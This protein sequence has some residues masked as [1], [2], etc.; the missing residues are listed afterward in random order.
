MKRR[1]LRNR[2]ASLVVF[3]LVGV[4][5]IAAAVTSLDGK[6]MSST[7]VSTNSA[8]HAGHY[9]SDIESKIDSSKLIDAPVIG[10]SEKIDLIVE[11]DENTLI[12]TYYADTKG[13]ASFA[14]YRES[15]EGRAAAEAL[16][17]KQNAVFN[18]I[19]R[20]A[21]VKL[22]YNYV[23][24]MNGFSMEITYGDREII[25][26][27][28]YK[29]NVT[30]TLISERYEAPETQDA[31]AAVKN[32]VSALETG[33]F[34]SSKSIDDG[35]A[36]QG[37]VVGILDTGIDFEHIAFDPNYWLFGLEEQ[38][39]EETLRFTKDYIQNKLNETSHGISTLTANL[40][41]TSL[42]IDDVYH[43]AKIPFAFDYADND[44]VV[45]SS[46]ENSH[47]THVAGIIAGHSDTP[48]R[49]KTSKN[50]HEAGE[51]F[52]RE[53]KKLSGDSKAI[54]YYQWEELESG[55]NGSYGKRNY[56]TGFTEDDFEE[57]IDEKSKKQVTG[58]TGVAPAAQLA[59]F[60]VF[61]DHLTTGAE[62]S[63]LLAALEDCV[64]LDVDA[65]N[66]SLGADCGFQD[67]TDAKDSIFHAYQAV[68]RTGISLVV[69]ASNSFSSGFGSHYGLNL[70]SNPDSGMVG[71]PASYDAS[72]TVASISG[73]ESQY[74]LATD[75]MGNEYGAAYYAE[76]ATMGSE[77][78]D[79]IDDLK[80][81]LDKLSPS[82]KNSMMDD[83]GNIKIEYITIPGVGETTDFT[84]LN[85][86]NKIA[87][88]KRGDINFEDKIKNARAAG[89]IACVV[90]NNAAGMLHMQIGDA[91]L[92]FPCC[93]ITMDAA[94]NIKDK[95]KSGKAYFVINEENKAGPFISDFSSW[96]PLPNLV[97]KPEITAHGGEIYSAIPGDETAYS[98]LSGTSMA[99]P[100]TS[101]VVLILRQYLQNPADDYATAKMFGIYDE[102]T[103]KVNASLM[104]RRIYQLLMSTAT[105]AHNEQDNPYSPRKQGAGLADLERARAARQYLFVNKTDKDGKELTDEDGNKIEAERTKIELFDDPNKSG[106]YKMSFYARNVDET[107]DAKYQLKSYVMT[108]GISTDGKTVNEMS[109]VFKL[110]DEY[111]QTIKIGENEETVVNAGDTITVPHGETIKITYTIT[112]KKGATDWLAQFVNGMYVDGFVCLENEDEEGLDLNIPYLAFYGDWSDAPIM[113]YDVYETTKDE[114]DDTIPDDDKRYAG[115]RPLMLVGKIIQDGQEYSLGMGQFPFTIPDEFESETPDA[116]AD[117][118]AMSFDTDSGMCGLYGVGGFLRPAKKLFWQITDALTGEV[119]REGMYGNARKANGSGSVGGAW[120]ELDIGDM[121]V[122]NNV[123][124]NMAIYPVIDWN[125]EKYS[126]YKKDENGQTVME[127]GRPVYDIQ[128]NIDLIIAD[129]EAYNST[130]PNNVRRY[131]WTSDFWVDTEAPFI[132]NAEVNIVRNNQDV[133]TY[134]LNLDITDNHYAMGFGLSAFDKTDNKYV[135]CFSEEGMRPING[136]R[137]STTRT[138]FDIT[139]YWDQI[140]DGL[141]YRIQ[142]P[143]QVSAHPELSTY[144]TTFRVELFDYAFNKSFY[145]I[146]LYDIMTRM[147]DAYFG[148]IG[149]YTNYRKSGSTDSVSIMTSTN[150]EVATDRLGDPVRMRE[151]NIIEGQKI[152]LM[153]SVVTTPANVWR[154]DYVF[155]VSDSSVLQLDNEKGE[156][157]A[158][159]GGTS[160][161]TIKSLSNPSVQ[162]GEVTVHVLS[163]EEAAAY[164]INVSSVQSSQ[165]LETINFTESGKVFNAGEKYVVEFEL[166][167]WYVPFDPEKYEIVWSVSNSLAATVEPLEY[168]SNDP[169]SRFKATVTAS[170]GYYELDATGKIVYHKNYS[171]LPETYDPATVRVRIYEKINGNVSS[172]ARYAAEFPFYVLD[173]FE[174]EGNELKD[175]HGTP[176]DFEDP[177]D[178]NNYEK[179]E[180]GKLKVDEFGRL[181]PKKENKVEGRIVIPDNINIYTIGNNV[182]YRRDDIFSIKFP[183]NLTT[184]GYASCAY[185]TKLERVELPDTL[186]KIDGYAF[187]AYTVPG[188]AGPETV[189]SIVDFTKCAKPIQV[190]PYAFVFQRYIGVDM[191]QS[192][193]VDLGDDVSKQNEIML[194]EDN[195]FSLKMV[196]VAGEIS[197]YG[198]GFV[199]DVDVSGLRTAGNLA[200]Y[201][202]GAK[203]KDYFDGDEAYAKATFGENTAGGMGA[204]VGTGIGSVT[205]KMRRVAT[206]MFVGDTQAGTDESGNEVAIPLYNGELKEITFTADD[207][208][209]EDLAFIYSSVEKV[210][211][212]GSVKYLGEA[213]FGYSTLSSVKFEKSCEY[214]GNQAFYGTKLTEVTLPKGLKSM[215]NGVFTNCEELTTVKIDEGCLLDELGVETQF[216]TNAQP[217]TFVGCSKLEKF[218]I[219]DSNGE[220]DDDKKTANFAV[221]DGVL[222][223]E[224]YE[225]LIYVPC[226]KEVSDASE[227][228][229]NVKVIASGAF[230]DHKHLTSIDLSNVDEIGIA[231]FFDCELLESVTL[232]TEIDVIPDQL[233]TGCTA[234]TTINLNECSELTSI[235]RFA[236]AQ[237]AIES[238]ELPGKVNDIG[239]FAFAENEALTSFKIT[240]AS[241]IDRIPDQMFYGC[242]NLTNVEGL[243]YVK[244][245][246]E[247]AFMLTGISEITLNRCTE[248]GNDAFANCANLKKVNAPQLETIGEYAFFMDS[249]E[250]ENGALTGNGVLTSIDLSKVKTIGAYAFGFQVNLSSVNL[251]NCETIGDYAF[252]YCSNLTDVGYFVSSSSTQHDS[253]RLRSI[254]ENA[255]TGTQVTLNNVTLPESLEYVASSAFA[256][257]RVASYNVD[258]ENKTYFARDGVLYKNLGNDAYELVSF[259][260]YYT[261]GMSYEILDGTVRIDP[262]SFY[263]TEYLVKVDI[264]DSVRTI[265][266]AA[267]YLSSIKFY[268]FKT[269]TAPELEANSES[270]TTT[271]NDVYFWQVYDNFYMPF[272]FTSNTFDYYGFKYNPIRIKAQDDVDV[273]IQNSQGQNMPLQNDSYLGEGF[274]N[275]WYGIMIGYPSNADGFDSF[276]WSNYFDEVFL[277]A[278]LVESATEELMN[279][280]RSLPA[281]DK[282][283]LADQTTVSVARTR[284]NGLRS[285]EQRAFVRAEGLV[286]V[287]EACEARIEKLAGDVDKATSAV[288]DLI[289]NLPLPSEITLDDEDDVI[290]AREAYNELTGDNKTT[291]DTEYKSAL[292]KLVECEARIEALK[293]GSDSKEGCGSCS[294]V[295]F[296]SGNGG[297]TGLMIGLGAVMLACLMTVLLRKKR[298]DK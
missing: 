203:L 80:A 254:G 138:Q 287:L 56:V 282:L 268:N 124:Y 144:L 76:A 255:F 170:D 245:V 187:A 143:E 295:A 294:T 28:A 125:A 250:D 191:K 190:Q 149:N 132:S 63:F 261:G 127:M 126:I 9:D 119:I 93:S 180:N 7:I 75:A 117:K 83:K 108:E 213:A 139:D 291:F 151:F 13:Y 46:I 288:R 248:I 164:N 188:G 57:I 216:E 73:V 87:L 270:F 70:T 88:V 78:C 129:N 159:K 27:I 223:S 112:L 74:I 130:H 24:V 290:A 189:L 179:D 236:F 95:D 276:V 72:F 279:Y 229:E 131:Y 147:S 60:K 286:D 82:V 281:P 162:G 17:K 19:A 135:T 246:G 218:E 23:N 247:A 85:L 158:L 183:H 54:R 208:V 86:Q 115:A 111:D 205:M 175:Y 8:I 45:S 148:D 37:M 292:D 100:N 156:I 182:F 67:E 196:R 214:I 36:G 34:D 207:R 116:T 226:N 137:N 133:A 234:L 53:E 222:Y 272:T 15:P 262:Y 277:T 6:D 166:N 66:M 52:L 102:Q 43:N 224:D 242:T 192:H 206:Q 154:E 105:I 150:N 29:A 26:K 231:A 142:H 145:E 20:Q 141:L 240:T 273:E 217:S 161:V 109:H 271:Y 1:N 79:F 204:F 167:P 92:G 297:G 260:T 221:K 283:T 258:L 81:A 120:L 40:L 2:L 118:C 128:A 285:D 155:G 177:T 181:T 122:Q 90:Y 200:F 230:S 123:R 84:G 235:G 256:E 210:T 110:N 50:G 178:P 101:G 41:S 99:C 172:S 296:G 219:V 249:V 202:I 89:A 98:R 68:E 220:T 238:V 31:V 280:I 121:R 212:Q 113:D 269:L 38:Q 16:I 62:S 106:V 22:K 55:E 18:K 227:L 10:K 35:F 64:T 157:Y 4:M 33:I 241:N 77:Y 259:P 168:D 14:E 165:K 47:G 233:F 201:G 140:Q 44:P 96:G 228:L 185:M 3:L 239:T 69:A 11:M 42:T 12:D 114:N 71:S 266:H 267:F 173:E 193:I 153:R 263:A 171:I 264:P 274:I 39:K 225:T 293:N 176:D 251:R 134:I 146:D 5:G 174:I 97:L 25:D 198:L 58:I 21:D 244:S 257:T 184:I 275:Q 252:L 136:E 48:Y 103:H 94:F 152:N 237:T 91:I 265:G 49:L 298:T 194:L 104:E 232:P 197:F 169:T 59:I 215:G 163:K 243:I 199:N 209:I 186:E 160:T 51:I 278:E 65:I 195:P 284:F 61:S 289:D 107:Y 211:F 253:G 30:N 32:Q